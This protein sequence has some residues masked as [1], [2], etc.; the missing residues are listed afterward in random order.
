MFTD[1]VSEAIVR[2][3]ISVADMRANDSEEANGALNSL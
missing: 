1:S 2:L 3:D